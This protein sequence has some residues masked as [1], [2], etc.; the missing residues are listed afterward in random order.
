[1]GPRPPNCIISENSY[2]SGYYKRNNLQYSTCFIGLF[3]HAD[4]YLKLLKNFKEYMSME[5]FETKVS[6]YINKKIKYPIGLLG[7][8]EIHFVDYKNFEEAVEKWKERKARMLPIK[9]CIIVMT[10]TSNYK[11]EHGSEFVDLPFEK[12]R[13]LL[14][15][16]YWFKNPY[17]IRLGYYDERNPRIRH[18][19]DIEQIM[20]ELFY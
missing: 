1:M 8:I 17:V 9:D 4:D 20:P 12:K 6:K 16:K 7:D 10:D 18:Y 13:L 19:R 5:I 14:S 15:K 11:R 3:I 2:G